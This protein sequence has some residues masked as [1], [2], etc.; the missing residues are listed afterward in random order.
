MKN[1]INKF[2][3]LHIYT[4]SYCFIFKLLHLPIVTLLYCFIFT[5]TSCE[6][7]IVYEPSE[8]SHDTFMKDSREKEKERQKQEYQELEQ[9]INKHHPNQ[10]KLSE[11]GYWIDV[12]EN[13][14]TPII[15][16]LDFVQFKKQY[17]NLEF[18]TIY[19][20]NESEIQ[21]IILGKTAEIRGIET[22]L[23]MLSEGDK[24]T[25]ILPSFMAYG[26]YGDDRKIGANIPLIVELEVL[27]VKKK[28]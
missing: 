27:K 15:Q 14:E 21:N 23:R 7:K 12:T 13:K 4:F 9:W 19:T 3:H 6:K 1:I 22:A 20:F 24:A 28:Q 26:L 5:F 11:Y 2:T 16:E 25:L 18:N 8:V 17:K 10:F